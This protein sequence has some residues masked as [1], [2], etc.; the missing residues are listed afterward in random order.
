M[1]APCPH[2]KREAFSCSCRRLPTQD[3]AVQCITALSFT[4]ALHSRADDCRRQDA[5]VQC[6]TALSFTTALH[7]R[8]D[9]CRRQDAG[10]GGEDDHGRS[11]G[12]RNVHELTVPRWP[13][14]TLASRAGRRIRIIQRLS[15]LSICSQTVNASELPLRDEE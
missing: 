14:K 2:A 5:A 8:A 12:D 7:S 4:T 6:T 1:V 15:E 13:T 3:A 10:C 11:Q 9:D